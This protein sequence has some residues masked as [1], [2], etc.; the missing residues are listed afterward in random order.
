MNSSDQ[1]ALQVASA[2]ADG[3]SWGDGL[4]AI[5]RIAPSVE[6]G[7][8]ACIEAA[9]IMAGADAAALLLT[10]DRGHCKCLTNL[11]HPGDPSA[12][13][14][15]EAG[16]RR[17]LV[18]RGDLVV[19]CGSSAHPLDSVHG[20]PLILPLALPVN[21]GLRGWLCLDG[22]TAGSAAFGAG[23]APLVALGAML[24]I[25][26]RQIADARTLGSLYVA[27]PA[28]M[29][30]LDAG[31]SIVAVTDLWLTHFGHAR[32]AVIGRDLRG[33]MTAASRD[34]YM[35]A[36]ATLWRSGGWRDYPCQFVTANGETAEV[37]M[38]A[39]VESDAEG[40]PLNVKCVLFDVTATVRLQRQLEVDV[41][42]DALTG[43]WTR[44]WFLSRLYS[45]IRR[46]QRYERRL[47]IAMLDAD[48][49]KS[50]NDDCGHAAG[51]RVL[52]AIVAEINSNLRTSDEIGRLGGEEFAL[53]LPETGAV[54]ALRVAERVRTHVADRVAK[55][56][57]L[58]RA[59][60][61]SVG[62]AEWRPGIDPATLLAQA[63]DALRRAKRDGRN[64]SLMHTE[65]EVQRISS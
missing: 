23:F 33:F 21:G 20:A 4:E 16:L 49:F 17:E 44:G 5:P 25:C 43:A 55:D 7:L 62:V 1:R 27:T 12:A 39:S 54:E 30:M 14:I 60:T 35:E 37:L 11:A 41:R 29:C 8:R 38:S 10:D 50:V 57:G 63:D 13:A 26:Q 40:W 2:A 64:R 22:A 53:L 48:H 6:P 36:R 45:E 9:R 34:A 65:P 32:D 51:D 61:I 56:A 31:G 24:E 3:P 58:V 28:L 42:T 47:S 18:R 52:Q 59:L 15:L 46:A 19:D